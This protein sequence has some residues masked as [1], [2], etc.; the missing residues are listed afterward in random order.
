MKPSTLYRWHN[1]GVAVFVV[2]LAVAAVLGGVLA[3]EVGKW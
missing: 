2:L 3:G 1:I